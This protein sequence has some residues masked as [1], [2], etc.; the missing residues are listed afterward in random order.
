LVEDSAHTS[1]ERNTEFAAVS[2]SASSCWHEENANG[3]A[4]RIN[5]YF[6]MIVGFK[7]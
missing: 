5:R 7:G 3:S 4:E 2:V 6:F 1:P